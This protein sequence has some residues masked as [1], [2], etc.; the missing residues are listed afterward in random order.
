VDIASAVVE[1]KKNARM[2]GHANA[3][4]VQNGVCAQL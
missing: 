4:S 3:C 2:R 1:Q